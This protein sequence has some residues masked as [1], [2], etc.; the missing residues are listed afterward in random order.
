MKRKKK[1]KCTSNFG[2]GLFIGVTSAV[3]LGLSGLTVY[4]E[5]TGYDAFNTVLVE[6]KVYSSLSKYDG[7]IGVVHGIGK[8]GALVQIK[9]CPTNTMGL[10]YNI[11]FNKND[12]KKLR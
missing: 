6:T 5:Y 3:L 11:H 8:F 9:M 4:N 1:H 10:Y 12:L 7:C 2:F